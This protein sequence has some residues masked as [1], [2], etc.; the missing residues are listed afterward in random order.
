MIRFLSVASRGA[1]ASRSAFGLLCLGIAACGSAQT[2]AEPAP[3]AAAPVAAAAPVE[4]ATCP[5]SGEKF[6][7][8]ATS[9]TSEYNGKRY[10]FCCPGC[11]KKFD[12]EPAK[13]AAATPGGP[14]A[15]HAPGKEG[16]DCN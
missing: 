11:K 6:T 5:V 4:E 15:A 9:P 16:C 10:V 14:A 2:K 3:V 7:P 12:A 1:L 8:S 13:F